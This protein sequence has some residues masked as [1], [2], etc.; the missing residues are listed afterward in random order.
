MPVSR[1]DFLKATSALAAAFGLRAMGPG[2]VMASEEGT[3]V[4][5]LQAQGCTGCSI[6]LLNSITAGTAEDL[7]PSTVDLAFHPTLMASA[8]PNAVAAATAAKHAGAYVLV[9]E[10]AIPTG[11]DGKYC[12]LWPG[13]TARDGVRQFAAKAEHVVAV[14]TCAAYGGIPASVPAGGA[15][16]TEA[17][18]VSQV[19]E[20]GSIINVPGCPPHPDW[21]VGAI[22]GLLGGVVPALDAFGRPDAYF[23]DTIHDHCYY[24]AEDYCREEEGCKGQ[25]T[26]GNCPAVRWNGGTLGWRNVNWCGGARSPC[27][28]CTHPEFPDRMLPFHD[29]V[30]D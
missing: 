6:S 8:G 26:H 11:A 28:G 4:V 16:P 7:I 21:I 19:V 25:I 18:G 13:M 23:S 29:E 24:D 15:N 3:S 14:G 27:Q 22:A 17:R 5:W 9:V 20:G 12:H 1:R 2:S 10:G 30:D